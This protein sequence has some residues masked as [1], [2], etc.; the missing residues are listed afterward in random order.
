MLAPE[1]TYTALLIVQ[2]LHLLHHRVMKRHISFAEVMSATVLCVPPWAPI[3]AWLL[4]A[5]HLTLIAVQV[6]GSL[7]IRRLSPEWRGSPQRKLRLG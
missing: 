5:T 2:A 3:P 7:F 4:S 6:V 1:Y